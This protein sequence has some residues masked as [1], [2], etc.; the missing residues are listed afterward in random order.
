MAPFI[1]FFLA[2]LFSQLADPH[3]T[4]HW[5]TQ[6]WVQPNLEADWLTQKQAQPRYLISRRILSLVLIGCFQQSALLHASV[7]DNINASL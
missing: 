6:S 7:K 1:S 4:S 3:L 2:D 5:L